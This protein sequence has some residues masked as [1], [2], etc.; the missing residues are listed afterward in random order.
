MHNGAVRPLAVESFVKPIPAA[1]KRESSKF[2]LCSRTDDIV[3]CVSEASCDQKVIAA[4]EKHFV[5]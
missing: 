3:V 4:R 2:E 5:S 1:V